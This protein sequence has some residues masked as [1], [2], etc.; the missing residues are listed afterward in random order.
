MFIFAL[1]MLNLKFLVDIITDY[2]SQ[3]FTDI[4]IT[5]RDRAYHNLSQC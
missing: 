3:I 5:A 2:Y 1:R 4:N